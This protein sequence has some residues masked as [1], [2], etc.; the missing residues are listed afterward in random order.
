MAIYFY[1]KATS[2]SSRERPHT[3]AGSFSPR[4]HQGG[5]KVVSHQGDIF[6]IKATS[7]DG[8]TPRQHSLFKAALSHHGDT[9]TRKRYIAEAVSH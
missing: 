3:K 6:Y 7:Q 2:L 9:F 1:I 5:T 4:R 8:F